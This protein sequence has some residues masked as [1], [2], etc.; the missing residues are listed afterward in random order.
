MLFILI[1]TFNYIPFWKFIFVTTGL[2]HYGLLKKLSMHRQK[3]WT[4]R[5]QTKTSTLESWRW[6]P[7]LNMGFLKSSAYNRM[8]NLV[9]SNAGFINYRIYLHDALRKDAYQFKLF[10]DQTLLYFKRQ[11]GWFR[12][13][14][15]LYIG[16]LRKSTK[17]NCQ[18]Y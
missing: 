1:G 10:S 9:Y 3:S 8:R 7:D 17:S 18:P 11:K 12:F 5:L 13:H 14:T 2:K 6:T 4:I 15:F 16:T